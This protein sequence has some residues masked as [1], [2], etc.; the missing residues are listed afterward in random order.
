M[1]QGRNRL[2]NLISLLFLLLALIV[3]LLVVARFLSPA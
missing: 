3:V 2:Y 1:G